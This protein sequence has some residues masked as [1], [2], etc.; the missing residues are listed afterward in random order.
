MKLITL[1]LSFTLG[2][3]STAFAMK[4]DQ[5]VTFAD[6]SP[7]YVSIND[8]AS[9]G[10]WTN[11]KEVKTYASDKI[12]LAGGKLVPTLE[13]VMGQGIGFVI[14]VNAKRH[15]QLGVCYGSVAVTTE[16]FGTAPHLP[17][18]MGLLTISVK[19]FNYLDAGNFNQ[20]VLD[21]V[22][23]ALDEWK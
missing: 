15:P 6:V 3:A 12:E 9:G 16:T 18:V 23:K 7:I 13:D 19:R 2:L 14:I 1:I 22:S 20:H 11:L 5:R 10:C 4:I 21:A 17:E 8:Y